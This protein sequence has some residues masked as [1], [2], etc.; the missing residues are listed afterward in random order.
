MMFW[1]KVQGALAAH[2]RERERASPRLL[3]RALEA[4][5]NISALPDQ[6]HLAGGF[7]QERREHLHCPVR[8][9][10]ASAGGGPHP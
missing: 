9:H 3:V 2:L 6:Q 7:D 8:P 4:P 10:D 5:Q 1:G